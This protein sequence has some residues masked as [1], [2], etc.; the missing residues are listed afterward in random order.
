MF[1]HQHHTRQWA[2]DPTDNHCHTIYTV[3]QF[4]MSLSQLIKA[5]WLK[6]TAKK[7]YLHLIATSQLTCSLCIHV[8][9]K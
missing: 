5:K 1:Q 6:P 9:Q 8:D 2:S 3:R 7:H 4:K